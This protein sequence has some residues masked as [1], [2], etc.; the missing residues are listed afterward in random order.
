MKLV[1]TCTL[2]GALLFVAAYSVLFVA[3]G[4]S[5]VATETMFQS[6]GTEQPLYLFAEVT[7]VNALVVPCK[8]SFHRERSGRTWEHFSGIPDRDLL[9]DVSDGDTERRTLYRAGEPM[10][11]LDF[12]AGADGSIE[13]Y[14]STS[15]RR[16][17]TCVHT[18]GR[19]PALRIA[20]FELAP[21]SESLVSMWVVRERQLHIASCRMVTVAV[22]CKQ[23]VERYR[24]G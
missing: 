24:L 15:T 20:V 6:T 12:A 3:I 1:A 18:K 10:P 23:G 9:I 2:G 19:S 22:L 16:S 4:R 7:A 13:T 21:V 5:R 14:P 8:S 11:A 17:C